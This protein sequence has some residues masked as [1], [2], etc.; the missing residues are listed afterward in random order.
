MMPP[1]NALGPLG[2]LP[3]VQFCQSEEWLAPKSVMPM[4]ESAGAPPPSSAAQARL[5]CDAT[6][7]Q[8][9]QWFVGAGFSPLSTITMPAQLLRVIFPHTRPQLES[10]MRMPIPS[11]PLA[12]FRNARFPATTAFARGESPM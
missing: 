1:L 12:P 7:P 3:F 4:P 10:R 9:A 11:T 6:L 5:L 8:A 2:R